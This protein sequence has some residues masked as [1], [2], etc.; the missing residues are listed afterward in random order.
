[1]NPPTPSAGE[2]AIERAR[3]CP[4]PGGGP[5]GGANVLR[6]GFEIGVVGDAD[7]EDLEDTRGE[8]GGREGLGE[9]FRETGRAS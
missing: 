3:V 9:R 5:G 7:G 4:T 1:M 2:P 6:L 8:S